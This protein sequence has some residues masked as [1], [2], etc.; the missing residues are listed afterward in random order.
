MRHIRGEAGTMGNPDVHPS[1]PPVDLLTTAREWI[2]RHSQ[3]NSD[4]DHLDLAARNL[5]DDLAQWL[6]GTDA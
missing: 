1:G 2:W 4:P 6:V 3:P 5:L